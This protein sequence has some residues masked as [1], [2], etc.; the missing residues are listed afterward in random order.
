MAVTATPIFGQTPQRSGAVWTPSSTANTRND[1]VGTIGTSMLLCYTAGANGA[2]IDRIRLHPVGLVAATA[3]TATV[4]RVY[5][6]T[7]SSGS[8]TATDTKLWQEVALPAQTTA[9][10]TTA[11]VPID[12]PVG[13]RIAA[14]DDILF[15]MHHVAAA[16][17]A[18]QIQ[19][20]ATD[21]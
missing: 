12:I 16:N 2:Y 10:T 6:S 1:G 21:Y 7:V 11:T 9:Q 3:T 4:G 8:T 20:I 13:I 15:S 19:V 18:W 5:L 17:T 14:S